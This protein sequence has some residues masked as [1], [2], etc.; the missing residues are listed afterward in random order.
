MLDNIAILSSV[1][2]ACAAIPDGVVNIV[3]L[4]I[5]SIQIVVPILLIIW[6]MIDFAKSVVGGDEDKIKAGQKTFMRRLIA[7]IVV[8]LVITVVQLAVRLV[9]QVGASGTDDSNSIWS[10]IEE[11]INGRS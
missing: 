11:F 10:C 7:A 8:F 4:I 9:G 5:K 2:D 6:G 1:G 3:S